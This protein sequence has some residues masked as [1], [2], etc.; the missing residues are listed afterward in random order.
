MKALA[1]T[2]ALSSV[3]TPALAQSSGQVGGQID[4]SYSCSMQL[5]GI[6][7]MSPVNGSLYEGSAALPYTQSADT[8][9]TM[10]DAVL[11][12]PNG[13]GQAIGSITFTDSSGKT[14]ASSSSD[15]K[16]GKKGKIKGSVSET[17]TLMTSIEDT[18]LISG[19]YT[20]TATLSCEEG[21]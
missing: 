8:D 2:L 18:V 13:A 21:K 12:T 15:G 4:V 6:I 16:G 19:R 17:G 5:P 11:Q 1:I 9:Y 20:V 7:A 3:T 14:V 10:S